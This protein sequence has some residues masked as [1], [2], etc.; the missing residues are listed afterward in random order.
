MQTCCQTSEVYATPGDVERIEAH[1]GRRDFTEFRAPDDPVYLMQDDDPEWLNHVFQLDGTRRVLKR[2]ANGDCTFLGSAGCVLPLET[3]PIICRLYPF[4]YTAEGLRDELARGCP[5][6]LLAEGQA[7]LE[8][9]DIS[10][11][12]ALRWHAQLYREIK[13]EK[14]ERNRDS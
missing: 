12:D 2:E 11:V 13:A 5:T 8:A 14:S 6:E 9:L 10:R 3:R 1:T 7:L 4:D